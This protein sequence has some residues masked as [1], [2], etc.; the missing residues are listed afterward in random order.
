MINEDEKNVKLSDYILRSLNGAWQM[1]RANPKAMD[2]FD[3]S[4]DGFWKSFWAI[5]VMLPVYILW[6]F[7]NLQADPEAHPD[8][9]TYPLLSESLFFIFILPFSAFVMIYFTKFMKIGEN[10][11]A[12]IIAFNWVSALVFWVVTILTIILA[13][14][15][16]GDGIATFILLVVKFYLTAYVVWFTIKIS[17]NISGG[18]AIGVFLF[19]SLLNASVQLLLLMTFNPTYFDA[20]YA[21]INNLPS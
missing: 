18:L 13:S 5:G 17:L 9:I 16:V 1:V 12:M 15:L 7:F 4:S 14:G 2:Y 6:V 20:V 8:M 3:L 19:I 11:A 10:Y 21:A